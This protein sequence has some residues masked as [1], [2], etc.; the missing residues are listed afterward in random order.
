MGCSPRS[1]KSQTWLQRQ[2]STNAPG[3]AWLPRSSMEERVPHFTQMPG[4]TRLGAPSAGLTLRPHCGRSKCHVRCPSSWRLEDPFPPVTSFTCL[5]SPGDLPPQLRAGR[6]WP[7]RPPPALQSAEAPGATASTGHSPSLQ[8][9]LFPQQR[10]MGR[11]QHVRMCHQ[12]V[13]P[14]NIT[15]LNL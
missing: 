4:A 1:Y 13:S 9:A 2:L 3:Q 6:G 12:V 11:R 5:R 10:K 14:G 8:P 15:G 7:G